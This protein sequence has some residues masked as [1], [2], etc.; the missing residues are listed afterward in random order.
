ML[1][2]S[3]WIRPEDICNYEPYFNLIKLATR[4]HSN[5]VMVIDAYS[6]RKFYG[7]LVDLLEPAHN[8]LLAPHIIDNTR[9][10]EDWFERTSAC[11]RRC[12]ACE[13]CAEVLEKVLV[14][15]GM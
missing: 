7:N 4:M 3:S 14:S 2:N 9:F 13:Y 6:K 15:F 8:P 12:H 1:H 5:P 10:P 11:N